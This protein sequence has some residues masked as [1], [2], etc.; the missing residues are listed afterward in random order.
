MSSSRQ[1]TG[2][3]R[4]SWPAPMGLASIRVSS[5][6]WTRR[7]SAKHCYF[8]VLP[9]MYYRLGTCHFDI[10]RRDDGM[11]AVIRAAMNHLTNARVVDDTAALLAYFDAQ[12]MAK[13]G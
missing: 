1:S 10:P 4:P 6:T 2:I 12:D 3:C 7:V 11:S 9:D 8:C 5:F 13:P